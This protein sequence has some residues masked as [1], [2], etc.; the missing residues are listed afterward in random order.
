LET[1]T[2]NTAAPRRQYPRTLLC[3]VYKD[4]KPLHC[5]ET[6]PFSHCLL[7]QYSSAMCTT[8]LSAADIPLLLS[9]CS[10]AVPAEGGDKYKGK[11]SKGGDDCTDCA[12]DQSWDQDGK[13]GPGRISEIYCYAPSDCS[14]CGGGMLQGIAYKNEATGY[15]VFGTVPPGGWFG[16]TCATTAGCTSLVLQPIEQIIR[17]EACRGGK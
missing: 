4:N 16:Q 17:V 8:L 11:Y 3:I 13:E 1:A 7:Q 14:Q 12:D 5:V 6:A 9:L 2:V 10:A 15:K